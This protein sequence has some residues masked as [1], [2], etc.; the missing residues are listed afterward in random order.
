MRGCLSIF[1]TNTLAVV[2]PPELG[3]VTGLQAIP[4]RHV[5]YVAQNGE[6]WIYDTTTDALQTTQINIIGDAVDLKFVN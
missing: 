4:G 5:V 2:V 3:D 6:I 1:D